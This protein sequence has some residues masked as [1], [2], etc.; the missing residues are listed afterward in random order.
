MDSSKVK[1]TI[2]KVIVIGNSNSF[3]SELEKPF[4]NLRECI[5]ESKVLKEPHFDSWPSK[6]AELGIKVE[7]YSV[8][9]SGLIP[10][11]TKTIQLFKHNPK[12]LFIIDISLIDHLSDLNQNFRSINAILFSSDF[13]E[14]QIFT[15]N[16]DQQLFLI[17]E[18]CKLLVQLGVIFKLI[19]P[20]NPIYNFQ[21]LKASDSHEGY[22]SFL[23][24]H[25]FEDF[26]VLPDL[27]RKKLIIDKPYF[28]KFEPSAVSK[29]SHLFNKQ[30][31]KDLAR[32]LYNKILTEYTYEP[33]L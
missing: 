6:L 25:A 27:I 21:K 23:Y 17:N 9:A 22:V 12:A 13:I 11:L 14:K 19:S 29:Y 2:N 15:L 1:L 5:D 28:K 7:N 3:G 20:V 18:F 10:N 16:S 30:A 31:L 8:P 32:E 4:E 26:P 24:S 33:D